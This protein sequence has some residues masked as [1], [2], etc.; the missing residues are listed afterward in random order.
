[1]TLCKNSTSRMGF[2][3]LFKNLFYD[4][5]LSNY[6]IYTDYIIFVILT[7]DIE[8]NEPDRVVKNAARLYK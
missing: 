8:K 4:F 7:S 5:T 3:L 6:F 2:F 1:M